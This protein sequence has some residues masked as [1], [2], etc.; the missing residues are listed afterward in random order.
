MVFEM[1]IPYF[2]GSDSGLCVQDGLD[3]NGILFI[4]ESFLLFLFEAVG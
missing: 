1:L 3:E 2:C 4:D